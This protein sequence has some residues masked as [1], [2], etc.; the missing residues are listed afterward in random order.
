M[1]NT[2]EPHFSLV[3]DSGLNEVINNCEEIKSINFRQRV[4]ITHKTIDALISLALKKPRICFKH[5]FYLRKIGQNSDTNVIDMK[6]YDSLPHN[7]KLD[8]YYK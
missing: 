2:S 3:T 7:M 5:Y 1:N 8:I 4:N 6:S